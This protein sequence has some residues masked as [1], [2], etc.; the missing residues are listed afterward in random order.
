MWVKKTDKSLQLLHKPHGY[1]RLI[2][3]VNVY[4]A[5]LP[6][7]EEVTHITAIATPC[8]FHSPQKTQSCEAEMISEDW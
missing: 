6:V 4:R 2:E 3:T 7:G 5:S 1:T 8:R